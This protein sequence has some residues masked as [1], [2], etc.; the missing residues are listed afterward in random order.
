MSK[1]GPRLVLLTAVF[2]AGYAWRA[3]WPETATAAVVGALVL[4]SLL[5]AVWLAL[6]WWRPA[7]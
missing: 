4:I 2:L 3:Y 1:W 7:G 5:S 6:R